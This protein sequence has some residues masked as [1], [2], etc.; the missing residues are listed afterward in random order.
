MEQFNSAREA[1]PLLSGIEKVPLPSQECYTKS[2]ILSSDRYD[3]TIDGSVQMN[4]EDVAI[5]IKSLQKRSVAAL[6][7]MD[8]LVDVYHMVM[9]SVWEKIFLA[10]EEICFR[11]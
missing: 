8:K 4:L 9:E 5:K 7:K 1:L 2:A 11:C 6:N 3:Y 10:D